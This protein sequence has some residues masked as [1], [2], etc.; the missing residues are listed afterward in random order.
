[1]RTRPL[2]L[3]A[4]LILT[5]LAPLTSAGIEPSV[6]DE[7]APEQVV[8]FDLPIRYID[9]FQ[10]RTLTSETSGRAPCS[11]IQSDG[12]TAGDAGNTSATS[13]DLGSNPNSG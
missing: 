11:T 5:T 1:M 3:A 6:D 4:I 8:D 2:L 13:K 12:G 7:K 10:P 9:D